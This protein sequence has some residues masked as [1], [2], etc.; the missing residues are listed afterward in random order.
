VISVI[1]TTYGEDYWRELAWERAYPSAIAE[2]PGEVVLHHAPDLSIGP[3]RN[4]AAAKATQPWLL[5]LDADDELEPGYVQAMKDAVRTT[6]R[7]TRVLF[8]P[9]VRYVR[10]GR[11]PDP[12]LIPHKDLR[13]DNYLVIGTMIHSSMFKK[14]GGFSDYPHGFEDW[15]LWAKCW[16]RGAVVVP[17]PLATYRAF[18][19][20][21]SQHRQM[22][23]DRKAQV[24][25]HLRIQAELFPEGVS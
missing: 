1:I 3:A 23:R 9:S 18:I 20:P 15:S 16:K 8:Q 25:L 22:W 17:V 5:F 12:L 7:P 13:T 4:E 10:K 21:R 11:V 14:A 2:E 6:S 19:N 24:E